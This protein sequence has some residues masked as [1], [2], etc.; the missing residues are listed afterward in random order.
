LKKLDRI[1]MISIIKVKLGGG[2]YDSLERMLIEGVIAVKWVARAAFY[3]ESELQI[4]AI[5]IWF[6]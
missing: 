1:A 6:S 2:I 3:S 5:S 4:L